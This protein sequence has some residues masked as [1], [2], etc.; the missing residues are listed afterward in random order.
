MQSDTYIVI[1]FVFIGMVLF[2]HF[3]IPPLRCLLGIHYLDKY[4]F[5]NRGDNS[6]YLALFPLNE[7]QFSSE[8][9]TSS[10]HPVHGNINIVSDVSIEDDVIKMDSII[11]KGDKRIDNS[12]VS[13]KNVIDV[14]NDFLIQN[15]MFL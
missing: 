1:V 8:V 14:V 12:Y 15:E 6:K 2:G 4:P 10:N 9:Y 7:R 5:R 3:I 13:D 11:Y